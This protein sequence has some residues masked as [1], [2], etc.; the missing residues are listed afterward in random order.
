MSTG[1]T[2]TLFGPLAA[3][4]AAVAVAAVAVAAPAG[5][6]AAVAGLALI[7]SFASVASAALADVDPR[8]AATLTFV[9]AASGVSAFGIGAA[10]WSLL[11]GGAL[12]LV[13]R[14]AT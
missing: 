12:L 6:I 9:V 10:F 1:V 7:G 14:R 5:L 2:Y 4:V 13:L 3:A 8:E 11:A